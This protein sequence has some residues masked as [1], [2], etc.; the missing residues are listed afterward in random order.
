MTEAIDVSI[1]IPSYNSEPFLKR[2]VLSC[3]AQIGVVAEIIVVDD[4]GKDFTRDI[5]EMVQ[6][7]NPQAR[8]QLICRAG[9]LGQATARNEGLAAAKGRYIALLDS[10]DAFCSNSV[11]S[12]WVAEADARE[13]EM[14]I[15]RFYNVSPEMVRSPARR[16]DLQEGEVYAVPNAPQLVNVVSC[17]Q[18]LYSR[19]FL[20]Q[21]GVIFSPKLKQREDRLFVIEALLKAARVGVTELFSVDHY[22]VENSSFKQIDAGQLE[23]YTQHL[24]ELNAAFSAARAAGGSNPD[25]ERA[26]AII[27]LRQLDEYWAKI[28]RRLSSYKRYQPLVDRY[29]AELRDM[30]SDLPMLYPDQVLD[31]GQK[32]GFL[33]EGRMDLLRLALKQGDGPVLVSLLRQPKPPL[34]ELAALRGVDETADE[35]ITRSLSFRRN[36]PKAVPLKPLEQ[37]IKRVVLHTGLPKTGSSS[38]QQLLERNRFR[39]LEQGVHYPIYGTNREH[40][41]RRERTPGHANL[42]QQ[43]LEGQAAPALQQL[44]AEVEEVSEI[45]GRPVET[46]VLS[47]ENIV[48]HRFWEGG[49][50]FAELLAPFGNIPVEVVCVL[51]HPRSWLSSLYVEM[52]GN[53]WNKFTNRLDEFT[54]SLDSMGLFDF[55]RIASILA[56]PPQATKLHLG[57]FEKIRSEG[58][59]EPWFLDLLGISNA[60]FDPIPPGLTNESQTPLQAA[61]LRHLK[62]LQGLNRDDLGRL[63]ETVQADPVAGGSKALTRQMAKGLERFATSHAAQIAAYEQAYDQPAQMPD[64]VSD[65]DLETALDRHLAGLNTVQFSGSPKQVAQ[66]FQQLD[67]IY[68]ESNQERILEICRED[69]G[70]CV[71]VRL[72]PEETAQAGQMIHAQGC[73]EF[74]L[75]CWEGEA[76]ALI[77]SARL[78]ELW[79]AGIRD[80]EIEVPTSQRNGRRPFRIV[81]LMPDGSCWLVPPAY[82]ARL[83]DGGPDGHWQ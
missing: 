2:S 23:Q 61:I 82:L 74:A 34:A 32:D 28:C 45:A 81:R 42:V 20:E 51:R 16:I 31:T 15:S 3:L 24:V 80:V 49:S 14:L 75:L 56:A 36:G 13:L 53:P 5:L 66:F 27:Y 39:L 69:R 47:A 52:C 9:G 12:E 79:Q 7:D 37:Q 8:L 6:R 40:S 17:W 10:D 25:F 68:A 64:A 71:A 41:I 35:A 73:E 18:I 58:G 1:I 44:A 38:L 59:I 22:N 65:L 67:A 30:V 57:C 33:R 54:D 83:T 11:L 60:G 76:L 72:Q 4:Q 50:R 62:R 26:N 19:A 48:S 29:F 21:N 46:L 70:Q 63:F 77:D 43:I 78:A 55:E